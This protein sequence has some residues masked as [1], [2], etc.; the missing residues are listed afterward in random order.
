[1]STRFTIEL[2]RVSKG[3]VTG[4]VIDPDSGILYESTVV[5]DDTKTSQTRVVKDIARHLNWLLDLSQGG[6][7]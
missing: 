3:F 7:K 6:T 1:M 5:T 2:S 4:R